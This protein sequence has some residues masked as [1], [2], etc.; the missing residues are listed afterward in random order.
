MATMSA[1]A[2][3]HRMRILATLKV[4]G[5]IYVS[6]LARELGMS[7]PLLHLHLKKLEEAGLVTSRL[8][9]SGDGKAL[10]FFEVCDFDLRLT[11]ALVA[12]AA[13]SL[14]IKAHE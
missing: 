7:R 4:D 1:L 14:T 13:K 6:E 8:E 5:R 12:E 10:N 2:S 11:P 3:P 9:L